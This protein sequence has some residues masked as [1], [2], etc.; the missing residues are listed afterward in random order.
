M[1]RQLITFIVLCAGAVSVGAA[2][3]GDELLTVGEKSN[4]KATARYDEVMAWCK[5]YASAAPCARLSELGVSTEG[6]SIPLLLVADPP[7]KSADEAKRSGKLLCLVIANIHAGE[8][9]GKEALPILLREEFL[10]AHPPLLKDLILAV[11]PIYN[12]DGNERVSKNNR[13]GQVGP[14]EGMGQRGNAR[15]LDLNRDFIKLEAAETRGLVRFLNQW[16]PH[17]FIDTHTTN[18]SHH[19][20]TI[21]YEGPKSPAGDPRI[22]EFMRK[23]FFPGVTASF[24]KKTGLKAFYYGNFNRDHTAWTTYPAEARYGTTYFGLR[25]RLSVLS[26]AYSYAPYKTRVRATRDFVK[27]CLQFAVDHKAE[28]MSLLAKAGSAQ[29]RTGPVPVALRSRLKA[30]PG[31]AT[32]LGYV[33]RMENGRRVRGEEPKDYELALVNSFETTL[34]RPRPQAY[35]VPA[36]YSRAIET[37]KRHGLSVEELREDVVLEVEV[38]RIDSLEHPRQERLPTTVVKTTARTE[39]R[40]IKAGTLV[41]AAAQGTGSLAAYLLEAE[42]EDGLLTWGFF[43]QGL[44]VEGDYP[45]VR[46]V[47]TGTLFTAAS[48]PLPEDQLAP[49]PITF[50]TMPGGMR[51]GRGFRAGTNWYDGKHWLTVGRGGLAVVDA[52]TGASR[53]LFDRRALSAALAREPALGTRGASSVLGAGEFRMDP[54]KKG[55]LFTH[56]DDLFYARFD[57]SKVVRLTN[58][59]GP[60]EFAQFSPDGKKVAFVREFD[61]Y[62]VAID[63]PAEHRLTTGGRDDLRNGQA[64][65]VYFEEIFNRRWPAFWWSPD[66]THVAFMQ[67]DASMVPYHTVLDDTAS[68][69]RVEQTRYPRSGEPNPTVRLGIAPA[70]GGTITWADLSSYPPADFLISEVG[71]TPDSKAAY[72]YAQNRIQSWLDLVLFEPGG[73]RA[74]PRKLFRDAT[75]AWIESMGPI[76]AYTRDEFL[77]LSERDGYKHIY[78]YD[79]SGAE[80]P[81]LTQGDWEV[82][83]IEHVDPSTGWVYFTATKDE[84]TGANLYRVKPGSPIERLT[85]EPGVH[86]VSMSPDGSL[87]LDSSSTTD[88]P[89]R[90]RLR[91]GSGVQVRVTDSNPSHDLKQWRFGSRSHFQIPARDGFPLEAEL[92]LPPDLDPNHRYPVWFTTYAGPHTPTVSNSWGGGRMRDHAL[93]HEGFIVFHMDPR[94]ASGKGAKS[95]WVGY[96]TLGVRE[97]ED[98]TD[99]I[100]WLKQKSY[101][102]GDRIGMA[103]HSYGGYITSYALTHSRLFAAGI[104]GAPVTDWRDYDSIYT[105]RYMGLP[106][107][108]AEGYNAS[109]VVRAAENLH[110]RLLILHGAIDD[111][112]SLRNTMRL[113]KALEDA[114]KDFELMIYPGSRHGIFGAHYNR[115]QLDFIRRTLGDKPGAK[116]SSAGQTAA[117]PSAPRQHATASAP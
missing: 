42:S 95:A 86:Q 35:L 96:R 12:T 81:R 83:S 57:G 109:S 69:R 65:W 41:V 79:Y 23:S 46:L 55:F 100:E 59:K 2:A 64:V 117:G 78:R 74:A 56:E 14:D 98:I 52:R 24:E 27:E 97:L 67:F 89:P 112:V 72:C 17:L 105:E 88:A 70:A 93:A 54:A 32:V 21:T 47:G 91:D 113:V 9:C 58:H 84:P 36:E 39:S 116:S 104:A 15:G 108:N 30:A 28:I 40:M 45:V 49:R 13:P 53:P 75:K 66:G 34:S 102:D 62:T 29:A 8:V 92:I 31:K 90:S 11:V 107:D 5:A 16:N 7:V 110:G 82:R 4:F 85:P 6:R 94:G 50:E 25:N 3:A 43:D 10:A 106:R 44:K 20:Y 101:V 77:W 51:G 60:E 1:P 19:R 38:D 18:G 80:K 76:H 111:N 99:A 33:E 37:L 115:L 114:D 61:L 87:F 63:N 26:E 73:A 103:G 68:P 71:W 48:E 22:V